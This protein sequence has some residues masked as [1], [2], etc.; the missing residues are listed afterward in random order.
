M[1]SERG[2]A[3]VRIYGQEYRIRTEE[4]AEFVREVAAFVD[5]TMQGIASRQS[6]GTNVQVAV[7]AALNIAEELFRVRRDGN[8][9]PSGEIESRLRAVLERLDEVVREE[10]GER[11]SRTPLRVGSRG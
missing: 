10:P 6:V 3:T 8:G 7:F 9:A 11:A 1:A 4:S 5:Q 2:T